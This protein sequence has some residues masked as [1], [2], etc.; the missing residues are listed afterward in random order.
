MPRGKSRLI[1]ILN[2]AIF[3]LLEIAAINLLNRTSDREESW[4]HKASLR[5]M[6]ALWQFGEDVRSYFSL[7]EQ[8]EKLNAELT[9]LRGKL[10]DVMELYDVSESEL[11]AAKGFKYIPAKV[12]KMSRNSQRCYIILDKGAADGVTPQSGIISSQGIVGVIDAIDEHYSYGMTLMNSGISVSAKAGK[13]NAT[14]PL[15]WDGIHTDKAYIKELA[16][17]YEVAVGDTVRTS[18]Y[19]AI[20][21]PDIPVGIA[22]KT[23]LINGT[24]NRVDVTLLQ[25]FAN[26]RFVSIVVPRGAEEIRSLE[27]KRGAK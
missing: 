22:G 11:P 10:A 12:V 4:L 6:G 19:S 17:N 24:T 26:V 16:L 8:N 27:K 15:V 5:S 23:H 21:P 13:D 25:D 3:I 2:A 14:G 20:F 7:Q 18:G 9:D 1:V